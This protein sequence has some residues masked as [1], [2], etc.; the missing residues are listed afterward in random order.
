VSMILAI[1]PTASTY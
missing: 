1:M